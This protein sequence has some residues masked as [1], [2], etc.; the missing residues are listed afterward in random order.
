MLQLFRAPHGH[1]TCER[2]VATTL[3]VFISDRV[4]Q[5]IAPGEIALV[6]LVSGIKARVDR[7][8]HDQERKNSMGT[9]DV[10]MRRV[11]ACTIQDT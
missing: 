7:C 1:R 3:H 9:D 10:L 5:V 6:A 8:T 4:S 11:H 2:A